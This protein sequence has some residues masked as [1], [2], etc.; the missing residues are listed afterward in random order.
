MTFFPM[1]VNTVAGLAASGH[2]ER[3]LMHTYASDY[4]QTLLKLR[5]PAA[6]PFIFKAL[7][8]NSTLAMIVS[9]VAEAHGVVFNTSRR[10]VSSNT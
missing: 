7:K 2:I 9:I 10:K 6:A 1:L 8:I 4:W 3:D 5:L